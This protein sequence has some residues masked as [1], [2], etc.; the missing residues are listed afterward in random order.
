MDGFA[1][2]CRAVKVLFSIGR[3]CGPT[4]MRR[5]KDPPYFWPIFMEDPHNRAAQR[6][7]IP[8][9]DD[10][11]SAWRNFCRRSPFHTTARPS[12]AL[13]NSQSPSRS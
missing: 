1:V 10:R 8:G 3:A 11:L 9:G 7:H 6:R 2:P 12:V 4:A 13:P 5:V